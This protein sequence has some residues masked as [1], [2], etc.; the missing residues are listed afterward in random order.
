MAVIMNKREK[1]NAGL[2][3]CVVEHF[4]CAECPYQEYESAEYP[5]R[6]LHRLLNDIA[7][8]DVPIPVI[9]IHNEDRF[10]CPVCNKELHKIFNLKCRHCGQQLSWSKEF[11][12]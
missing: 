4:L 9:H 11:L 8:F 7:S 3:A 6:C 2:K 5:I 10:Y 12:N 1:V